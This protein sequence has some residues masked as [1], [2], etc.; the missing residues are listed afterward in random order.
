MLQASAHQTDPFAYMKN[1][2]LTEWSNG[3]G[4]TVQ[5]MMSAQAQGVLQD[6]WHVLARLHLM[7]REFDRAKKDQVTWEARRAGLGFGN[8]SFDAIKTINNNDWL[9]IAIA[10]VT[11]LDYRDYLR[12]WGFAFSSEA[13]AQV[14]GFNYPVVPRKY[15]IS[16]GKDY[17]KGLD[18]PVVRIDG[19]SAWPLP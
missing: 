1:A 18:K 4:I 7:E 17:C 2:N 15:Y 13:V 16:D 8:Y 6:G 14:A 12:M 5:M 10:Y 19:V 3:V 11:G 9:V